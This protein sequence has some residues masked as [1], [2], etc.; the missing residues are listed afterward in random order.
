MAKNLFAHKADHLVFR[1]KL[2]H[3][4]ANTFDHARDIP[5]WDY[6]KPCVHDR[7]SKASLQYMVG[8]VESRRLHPDKYTVLRQFRV[9]ELRQFK[10]LG[11]SMPSINNRLHG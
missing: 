6:C 11:S 10:D 5:T 2:R 9:R 3:A 8:R 7:V 4:C 1:S